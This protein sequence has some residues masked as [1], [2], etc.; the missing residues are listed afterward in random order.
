MD[1]LS[2]ASG[3]AGLVSL[4]IEVC[5]GL[6]GYCRDYR[7]R[8]SDLLVLN[9]HA[10][11]LEAFLGLLKRRVEGASHVDPA[12]SASL[13]ECYTAC[14]ACLQKFKVLQSKYASTPAATGFK[15]NGKAA[16][17]HLKYP[18]HKSDFESIRIQVQEFQDSFSRYL[19]LLNW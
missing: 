10:E 19:L 9:Q 8:H 11:N 4:G 7:S 12:L 13:D 5:K 1:P 18:F 17:R 15:E 16:V 2:A 14:N 3:V 6:N